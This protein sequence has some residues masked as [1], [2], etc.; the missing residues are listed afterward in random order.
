MIIRTINSNVSIHI[1]Y[2]IIP[3]QRAVAKGE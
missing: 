3:L 2:N 1:A